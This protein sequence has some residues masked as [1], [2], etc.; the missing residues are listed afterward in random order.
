MSSKTKKPTESAEPILC[1]AEQLEAAHAE[2]DALACPRDGSPSGKARR[3]AALCREVATWQSGAPRVA[4]EQVALAAE[5]AASQ[6]YA[7]LP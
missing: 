5:Y 7:R 4:T 6:T 3:L 2:L 1:S